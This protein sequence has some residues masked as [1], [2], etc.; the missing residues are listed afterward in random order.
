MNLKKFKVVQTWQPPHHKKGLQRFLGFAD[1]Y[2]SFIPAYAT[3]TMALIKLLHLKEPFQWTSEANQAFT[4]LKNC[5]ATR[6]LLQY[7]NPQQC[8]MLPA[9]HWGRCF[10]NGTTW[11]SRCNPVLITPAN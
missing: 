1:Y 8:P 2:Q 6:P 7:P 5:F 3:Q 11:H 4:A 10:P 9:Q